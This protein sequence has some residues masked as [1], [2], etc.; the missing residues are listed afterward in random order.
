MI[1]LVASY[2]SVTATQL[3]FFRFAAFALFAAPCLFFHRVSFRLSRQTW[4]VIV[5]RSLLG[6]VATYFI[7]YAFQWLEVSTAKSLLHS[8]PLFTG[9][10]ACLCLQ[11]RCTRFVAILSCITVVGVVLVTQPSAI[12]GNAL[13]GADDRGISIAG[14]LMAL[15]AAALMAMCMVLQRVLGKDSIHSQL[16]LFIMGSVGGI[17]NAVMTTLLGG[18]SIPKCG[19]VRLFILVVVF[20]GYFSMVFFILALQTENAAYVSVLLSADVF[21]TFFLELA[22]STVE[23]N[24]MTILGALCIVGSSIAIT[25]TSYFGKKTNQDNTNIESRTT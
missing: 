18:W 22:V 4:A 3:V 10:F 13:L 1:K 6:L 16:V 19:A 2:G 20:T 12:F 11:E 7:F 14:S 21:F 17:G 24:W 8:S 15:S 9:V 5:F 23:V 25:M